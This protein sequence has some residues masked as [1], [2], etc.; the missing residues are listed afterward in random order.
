[1]A[2]IIIAMTPYT[3]PPVPV[4]PRSSNGVHTRALVARSRGPAETRGCGRLLTTRVHRILLIVVA[5]TE[6]TGIAA[7]AG[8][9]QC[10]STS[11]DG[12][13][14]PG[15]SVGRSRDHLNRSQRVR[16]GHDP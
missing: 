14:A 10:V 12:L 3:I 16:R 8:I 4:S 2:R 9:T 1:M 11:C 13:R 5:R 6:S 7:G 15:W